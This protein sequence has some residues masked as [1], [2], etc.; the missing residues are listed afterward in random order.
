LD[1]R[2]REAPAVFVRCEWSVLVL[3]WWSHDYFVFFIY[4]SFEEMRFLKK[5]FTEEE[6]GERVEYESLIQTV[7]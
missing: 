7:L 6:K 5:G 2:K 1:K 4:I 3:C